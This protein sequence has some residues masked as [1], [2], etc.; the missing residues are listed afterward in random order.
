GTG[1]APQPTAQA[2]VLFTPVQYA[3]VIPA[4][5]DPTTDALTAP[6]ATAAPLLA[7]SGP[8]VLALTNDQS[9]AGGAIK[10]LGH[11]PQPQVTKLLSHLAGKGRR[12]V[13]LLGPDTVY[14]R[15]VA[16][17]I[18]A[19]AAAGK[20]TL[21]VES[22]Y[23]PGTQYADVADLTRSVARS[24][25]D[26]I[27]VPSGG[28]N[29]VGVSSLLQYYNAIPSAV[30][31]GTDVWES[32]TNLL[33]EAS[34]LGA[35]FAS[36]TRGKADPAMALGGVPPMIDPSAA[37]P[38]TAGAANAAAPDIPPLSP[39]EP[40]ETPVS[41]TSA[42]ANAT[43]AP[44][45][46]AS[47]GT[48]EDGALPDLSLE[49]DDAFLPPPPMPTD[50]DKFQQLVMDGVALVKSWA[51]RP[52]SSTPRPPLATWLANP[53]G[54]DGAAGLFR[55]NAQGAA[56]RAYNVLR[57]ERAGLI[58]ESPALVRF[59]GAPGAPIRLPRTMVPPPGMVSTAPITLGTPSETLSSPGGAATSTPQ[60]G[61]VSGESSSS[62]A[63]SGSSAPP[64]RTGP[65]KPSFSL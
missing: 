3:Q 21:A 4:A 24:G 63:P 39:P 52:G 5:A 25:A 50:P 22:L 14:A 54:F 51:G 60:S 13:A 28:L 57:I 58:T 11:S 7:G 23:A 43:P 34:L 1:T 19:M 55:F 45:A 33:R 8:V 35:M 10:V 6:P 15:L 59:A 38:E 46:D 32:G 53:A 9:V 16:N 20:L 30:I 48:P 18:K 2:P 47:A 37:A 17:E 61:P 40:Q 65:F 12:Q 49:E 31:A 42:G 27:V 64:L 36:T 26:V 62:P 56:E 41:G 29:L 44:A